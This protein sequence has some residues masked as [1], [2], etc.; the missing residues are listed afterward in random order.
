MQL[1]NGWDYIVCAGPVQTGIFAIRSCKLLMA[2]I[3][4]SLFLRNDNMHSFS[5]LPPQ[6]NHF[7][8]IAI[9]SYI[10]CIF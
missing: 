10:C 7:I 5:C 9:C 3:L 6:N 8:E 2:D 4:S 1:Q